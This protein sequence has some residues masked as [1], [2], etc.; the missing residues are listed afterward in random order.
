MKDVKGVIEDVE[1]QKGVLYDQM[2]E[3]RNRCGVVEAGGGGL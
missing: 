3:C 2:E 1:I